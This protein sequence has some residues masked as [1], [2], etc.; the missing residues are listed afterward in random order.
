MGAS[1]AGKSKVMFL[2]ENSGRGAML[3]GSSDAEL[4]AKAVEGDRNAYRGLVERYERK[5]MALAY[6]ITGSHEDA[7]D[8]VQESFVKAYLALGQFK[9]DAT[10]Y[11]W[12]YRIVYNMAID[13]KRKMAR[14]GGPPL[15][16]DES[17]TQAGAVGDGSL[18]G[19]RFVSAPELM[20]RREDMTQFRRLMEELTEEHRAVIILREV[21]GMSYEQIAKTLGVNKG[22][23]MS[24]L[25]YARKKL[26]QGLKNDRLL[27]EEEQYEEADGGAVAILRVS[28]K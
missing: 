20:M 3:R 14:R 1:R 27:E 16:F 2:V 18:A 8:V 11:T 28:A 9:G 12:L 4:V 6:E 19:D 13:F 17:Q 5:V 23:V 7:E 26:Q 15:E 22:T 21:E 25:F 24:R 10:F